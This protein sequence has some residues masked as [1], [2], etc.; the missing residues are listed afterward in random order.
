LHIAP[1]LRDS[2]SIIVGCAYGAGDE[3]GAANTLP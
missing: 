2:G 3:R 1:S